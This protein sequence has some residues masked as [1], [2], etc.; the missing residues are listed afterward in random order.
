MALGYPHYR[1]S[2]QAPLP[3]DSTTVMPDPSEIDRLQITC[4]RLSP[5]F[6]SERIV[7][8][9]ACIR[10]GTQDR[11]PLIGAVPQ[12]EGVYVATGHGLWVSSTRR[13]RAR[14]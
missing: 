11:L 9:Q 8:R 7:T 2:D 1:L 10:P 3:I 4:E 12:R 13:L 14:R 6:R 5:V